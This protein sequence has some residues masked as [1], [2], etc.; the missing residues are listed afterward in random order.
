MSQLPANT[1]RYLAS[2]PHNVQRVQPE[3]SAQLA[4]HGYGSSGSTSMPASFAMTREVAS[5]AKKVDSVV[6]VPLGRG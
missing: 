2:R 4:S 3:T 6:D 1:V 5:A